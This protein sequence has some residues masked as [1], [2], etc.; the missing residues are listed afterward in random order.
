MAATDFDVRYCTE[1]VIFMSKRDRV[2]AMS[3]E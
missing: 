1:C 3:V 2:Y